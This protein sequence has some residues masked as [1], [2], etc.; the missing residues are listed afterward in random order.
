MDAAALTAVALVMTPSRTW[1]AVRA[2]AALTAAGVAVLPVLQTGAGMLAIDDTAEGSAV[3]LPP[4]ET[5][6]AGRL[7][8][9]ATT[10]ADTKELA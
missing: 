8:R 10:I 4:A 6:G 7:V 3:A 1:G 9:A 5:A 2:A